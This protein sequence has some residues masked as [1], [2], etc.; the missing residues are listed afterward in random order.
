MSP[1]GV[2]AVG[3]VLVAKIMASGNGAATFR[4]AVSFVLLFGSRRSRSE[5]VSANPMPSEPE[6]QLQSGGA[7]AYLG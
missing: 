2:Y 3:V 4:H 1:A 7:W 5:T 6:G